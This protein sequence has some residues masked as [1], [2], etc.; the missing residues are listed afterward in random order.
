MEIEIFIL[1]KVKEN[2]KKIH[3]EKDIIHHKKL[4]MLEL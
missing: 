2:L 4:V 1:E 3:I